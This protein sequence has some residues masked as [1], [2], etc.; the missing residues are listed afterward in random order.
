VLAA[1]WERKIKRG[2]CGASPVGKLWE[3]DRASAGMEDSIAAV[4]SGVESGDGS[5][6]GGASESR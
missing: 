2:G 1:G 4:D 6:G 5:R 3:R